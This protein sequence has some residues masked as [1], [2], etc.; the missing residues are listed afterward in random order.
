MNWAFDWSVGGGY[1]TSDEGNTY[2]RDVACAV[3]RNRFD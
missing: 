3:S 2:A 1:R